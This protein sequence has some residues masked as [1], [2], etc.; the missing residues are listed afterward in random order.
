MPEREPH[1]PRLR[2]TGLSNAEIAARLHLR[3]RMVETHVAT[4]LAKLGARDRT[5]AV[6]WALRVRFRLTP[7]GRR[8]AAT[9]RRRT[10]PPSRP[11]C[12]RC[13]RGLT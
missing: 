4:V 8:V 5:R 11:S 9:A 12:R 2:A 13:P 3:V 1:A 7:R 6:I 10:G